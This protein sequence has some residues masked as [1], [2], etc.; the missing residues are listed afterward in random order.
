MVAAKKIKFRGKIYPSITDLCN[1]FK[2][3]RRLFDKRVNFLGWSIDKA[4]STPV[5][6]TKPRKIHILDGVK[7]N[8]KEEC[9]QRGLKYS[10]IT[11]RIN[12]HEW[13]LEE[14]LE[15]KLR[16]RSPNSGNWQI[17]HEGRIYNLKEICRIQKLDYRRYKTL[18]GEWKIPFEVAKKY[19]ENKKCFVCEK[20]VGVLNVDHDHKTGEL[21]GL[22]CSECNLAI[23]NLKEDI[24]VL[25][26]CI[27][28]LK[29]PPWRKYNLEIPNKKNETFKKLSSRRGYS[30]SGK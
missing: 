14:A 3:G 10:K 12:R 28:Y 15:I 6:K 16:K 26:N 13:T 29:N 9:R 11:N 19:N 30:Y 2:I 25:K 7:I 17:R 5:K 22:L 20:K 23:G 8:L 4:I 21:R 1:Q 24:K 18:T 27:N